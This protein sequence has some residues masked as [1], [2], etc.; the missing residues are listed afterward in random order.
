[1]AAAS[2]GEILL[3][4]HIQCDSKL[5]RIPAESGTPRVISRVEDSRST[6]NPRRRPMATIRWHGTFDPFRDLRTLEDHM[7]TFFETGTS[8][9]TV[10]PETA[11]FPPVDIRRD[12]DAI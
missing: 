1:M 11:A 4:R 2:S 10:A 5:L 8:D 12:A 3:N 9:T 7:S 6:A